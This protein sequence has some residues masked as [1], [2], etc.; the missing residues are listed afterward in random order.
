MKSFY[1][2]LSNYIITISVIASIFLILFGVAVILFPKLLPRLL[3]Y[4][5][6]VG[7]ILLGAAGCAVLCASV[8]RRYDNT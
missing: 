5:I 1:N 8:A 2:Y 7:S 6:A 3:T 4:G